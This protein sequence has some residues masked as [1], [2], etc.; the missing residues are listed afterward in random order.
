MSLPQPALD[1]ADLD[2][3]P[4][5]QFRLWLDQ[6]VAAPIKEPLAMAL[7][8]ATPDG[9]PS[10]RMVLLRGFDERGFVFFTNY[11][12][13][14]GGE[15]EANPR[16]ALAFY[17]DVLDRQVRIEGRVEHTSDAESDEYFRG[18]PHGSR[19]GA[20]ASRQSEVIVNRQVLERQMEEL[21]ARYPGE[22]PRPSCWGGYR[23]VPE[24]IEFWEGR[25]NRLHDRLRYVRQ[26][27]GGWRIERLSP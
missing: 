27:T 6:A 24:T 12:S 10:A 16:A 22:V 14:K 26:G 9:R 19:L 3:D 17:W 8:T 13:R 25:A 21:Q 15:M 5:R 7:A 23:V 4:F 11:D 18:R 20:W 2:P 1:E